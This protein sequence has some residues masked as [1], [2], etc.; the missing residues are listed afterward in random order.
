MDA[1]DDIRSL[2]VEPNGDIPIC[3]AFMMG[4]AQR[5][6][7]V[8]ILEQ[9]D[10]YADPEIAQ[11]LEKGVEG[12]IRRAQALEIPL[13]AEGYYSI[14]ELC[15]SIRRHKNWQKVRHNMTAHSDYGR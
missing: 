8:D 10:P 3:E 6:N 12:V 14:C 7:T 9:Y 2:C 1:L 15:T 13:N 5:Q 11:I 4:N